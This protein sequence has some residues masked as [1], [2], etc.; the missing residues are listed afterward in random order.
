MPAENPPL[1]LALLSFRFASLASRGRL[2]PL[3]L[4]IAFL[5]SADLRALFLARDLARM[6]TAHIDPALASAGSRSTTAV[7]QIAATVLPATWPPMPPFR[8]AAK[9]IFV[10]GC[11]SARLRARLLRPVLQWR[12]GHAGSAFGPVE[13]V[14]L[15]R[16]R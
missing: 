4:K 2:L 15:P 3:L 13:R 14:Q 6:C 9:K 10:S 11:C 5:C 7:G 1:Q 12:K 16:M 8:L